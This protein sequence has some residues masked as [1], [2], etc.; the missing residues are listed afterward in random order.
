MLRMRTLLVALLLSVGSA[1][2]VVLMH[3][4]FSTASDMDQVKVGGE[5]TA[6]CV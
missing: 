3:G 1:L 6:L 5:N 2:P 4:I